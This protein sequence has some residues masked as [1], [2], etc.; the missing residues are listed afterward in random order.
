M[1]DQPVHEPD[2]VVLG[3]STSPRFI[4][5]P[6]PIIMQSFYT[7][8]ELLEHID[9][10][11]TQSFYGP[12]ELSYLYH[13]R[14][15]IRNAPAIRAKNTSATTRIAKV[16]ER[17][18]DTYDGS[19]PAMFRH[20]SA[21]I[22]VRPLQKNKSV[23]TKTNAQRRKIRK[24]NIHCVEGSLGPTGESYTRKSKKREADWHAGEGA[25]VTHKTTKLFIQA[26]PSSS[27]YYDSTS[28]LKF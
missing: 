28:A 16:P 10:S 18:A 20:S 19:D 5:L 27:E 26:A 8:E 17:N 12:K 2:N 25:A 22:P 21:S 13:G 3:L 11:T 14:N 1:P 9:A 4:H 15:V 23:P 24:P 6:P 7:A